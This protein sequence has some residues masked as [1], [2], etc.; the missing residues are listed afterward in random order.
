MFRTGSREVSLTSPSEVTR[1][2][3]P[4]AR[5]A[6]FEPSIHVLESTGSGRETV[7]TSP[8]ERVRKCRSVPEQM[9]TRPVLDAEICVAGEGR[10]KVVGVEESRGW[11]V[12]PSGEG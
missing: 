8:V 12:S 5:T 1:Y 2:S 6:T 3:R 9:A 10:E 11:R 7:E 4:E